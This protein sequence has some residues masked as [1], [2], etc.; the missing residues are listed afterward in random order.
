MFINRW[1][2]KVNFI[3]AYGIPYFVGYLVIPQHYIGSSG[4]LALNKP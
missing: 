4:Y 1:T 2:N 3:F